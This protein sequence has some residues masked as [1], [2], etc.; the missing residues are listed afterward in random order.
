MEKYGNDI[1]TKGGQK[2]T[3]KE[4]KFR[5][6]SCDNKWVYGGY[7]KNKKGQE[8]I[9]NETRKYPDK[10]FIIVRKETVGQYTNFKDKNGKEIYEGD[11]AID[12]N[13][14]VKD[15]HSP[16]L[17]IKFHHWSIESLL[18]YSFSTVEVIGNV[19]ENPEL[20]EEVE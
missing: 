6:L 5:G 2:M 20:L 13:T 15:K 14:G 12:W 4:I 3:T 16:P 17:E 18:L 1:K 11:I 9:I 8:F 19:Y 7:Y 10:P